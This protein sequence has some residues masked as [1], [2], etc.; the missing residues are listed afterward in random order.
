MEGVDRLV[1]IVG[2]VENRLDLLIDVA[3]GAEPVQP[4]V[5]ERRPRLRDDEHDHRQQQHD[6]AADQR[7]EPKLGALVLTESFILWRGEVRRLLPSA[8]HLRSRCRVAACFFLLN[9]GTAP[10]A[11]EHLAGRGAVTRPGEE[12]QH[13]RIRRL[14]RQH[15]PVVAP[16]RVG[17]LLH[18]GRRAGDAVDR[19]AFSPVAL[20]SPLT[21]ELA[22]PT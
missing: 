2:R 6:H 17:L 22:R 5:R 18:V 21:P 20:A 12:L 19:S 1:Q 8:P 4:V 10:A 15:R 11:G 14:G 13:R 3:A 7:A 16:Q 9:A